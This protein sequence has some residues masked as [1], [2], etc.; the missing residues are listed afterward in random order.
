MTYS[1]NS[2][3][4]QELP[5]VNLY[6]LA[7]R[8]AIKAVPRLALEIRAEAFVIS[9]FPA[10]MATFY[11]GIDLQGPFR[12]QEY[13]SLFLECG[14][15]CMPLDPVL[16][17]WSGFYRE[18][19]PS[20]VSVFFGGSFCHAS[21]K[22]WLDGIL[23]ADLNQPAGGEDASRY[24]NF[25]TQDPNSVHDL[26]IE[27]TKLSGNAVFSF[28]FTKNEYSSGLG[29]LYSRS[30]ISSIADTIQVMSSVACASRSTLTV[31][32]G[33]A[34]A[35]RIF[36][37]IIS[38]S[39]SF[40]NTV[41]QGGILSSSISEGLCSN[42]NS[43]TLSSAGNT[44]VFHIGMNLYNV[45]AQIFKV[46]DED[47]AGSPVCLRV[48]VTPSE[49]TSLNTTF[50]VF[51][52]K[53]C[54]TMSRVFG[55]C[56]SLGTYP[57]KQLLLSNQFNTSFTATAGTPCRFSVTA[58]D[59]FGN[60]QLANSNQDFF[61]VG[62][63]FA[64]FSADW[65][66]PSAFGTSIIGSFVV[67]LIGQRSLS[68]LHSHLRGVLVEYFDQGIFWSAPLYSGIALGILPYEHYSFLVGD[69]SL[70]ISKYS[71]VGVRWTGFLRVLAP[72]L[73][74]FVLNATGFA[75][76]CVSQQ[77]FALFT[78]DCDASSRLLQKIR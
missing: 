49:S 8:F 3:N 30:M 26:R 50:R 76:L 1:Y 67:S 57:P 59:R 36:S 28:N 16:I 35:G 40:G 13:T 52:D 78:L 44:S 2:E 56:L 68:V 23:Q 77:Q 48:Y 7:G 21:V 34:T 20:T 12:V 31:E 10:L 72:Q 62:Q 41:N 32:R 55:S 19:A 18:S 5:T 11:S 73:L 39:D 65:A 74:T 43:G 38:I 42:L 27:Y 45:T 54:A 37:A 70:L 66:T 53:A 6:P 75:T 4:V 69:Q 60:L 58:R 47:I 29:T 14:V 22:L 33:V 51:P 25:R 24:I 71:R 17:R 64:R 46:Y 9:N 63:D 61:Y 15:N